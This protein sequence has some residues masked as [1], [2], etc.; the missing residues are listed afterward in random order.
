MSKD[1]IVLVTQN[2]H[3]LAELSPLFE[4]YG[5][6]FETTSLEK[7][8]IQSNSVEEIAKAAASHAFVTLNRPV[9]LDDTGFFVS[10]LK[11]FPGAFAAFVLQSIG[12]EGILKLLEGVEDRSARFVTAVGFCDGTHLKTFIGEVHGT[13]SDEPSGSEGFGYDPI[14]I[15]EGFTKTYADLTFTEKVSISHRSRAF[16][17]FL[18]W[19]VS[20]PNNP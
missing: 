9:V 7:L 12:Y 4:K 20:I 8:E 14:F 17:K 5:M 16:R 11:D 19:E 13:V 2:K 15:P 18:E 3:K 1:S 10:A 6:Q